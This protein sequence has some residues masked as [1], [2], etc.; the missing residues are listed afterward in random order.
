MPFGYI[1]QM[2]FGQIIVGRMPFGPMFVN[3]MLLA[4]S[5]SAK[6]LLSLWLLSNV[7]FLAK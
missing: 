5:L 7:F 2:P 4:I 6:Y 3:H 1:G